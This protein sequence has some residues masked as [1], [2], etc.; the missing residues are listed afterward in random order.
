MEDK[1]VTYDWDVY[2]RAGY[3]CMWTGSNNTE[4]K[5]QNSTCLFKE[6]YVVSYDEDPEGKYMEQA[7]KPDYQIERNYDFRA[8][9]VYYTGETVRINLINAFVYEGDSA[10]SFTVVN[11]ETNEAVGEVVNGQWV[12]AATKEEFFKI[13]IT[14]NTDDGKTQFNIVDINIE[15]EASGNSSSGS[16]ET[17]SALV[18]AGCGSSISAFGTAALFLLSA[19]G[20]VILKKKH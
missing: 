12:Y 14:A 11:N 4:P 15:E 20:A 9:D 5:A 18:E 13:K 8:E 2:E 17:T 19:A 7:E 16:S 1:G 10:L 6:M 3:L